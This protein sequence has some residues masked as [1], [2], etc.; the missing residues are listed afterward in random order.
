MPVGHREH[1]VAG[2]A[3]SQLRQG[4]GG[5]EG[6]TMWQQT[7]AGGKTGIT[8]SGR[9]SPKPGMKRPQPGS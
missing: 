3:G 7:V 9:L 5:R 4:G 6:E 8:P 2:H 1:G